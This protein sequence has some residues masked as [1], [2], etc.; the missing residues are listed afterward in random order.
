MKKFLTFFAVMFALLGSAI[1]AHAWKAQDIDDTTLVTSDN[2]T[3]KKAK[4]SQ[5]SPTIEI[6]TSSSASS[7]SQP[8]I[9][10]YHSNS[11]GYQYL[12]SNTGNAYELSIGK[13]QLKTNGWNAGGT[14]SDTGYKVKILN[15]KAS[16]TYA[17]T[18]S[19]ENENIYL[20]I[21][22]K[23][24][25][26]LAWT[27][28]PKNKINGGAFSFSTSNPSRSFT[29]STGVNDN[30]GDNDKPKFI[31][32]NSSNKYLI[33]SN[34]GHVKPGSKTLMKENSVDWWIVV[35][36]ATS[37]TN[38]PIT[39][40]YEGGS[41]Y[42]T[43]GATKPAAPTISVSNNM[44]T[45]TKTGNGTIYYTLDGSDPAESST[46]KVYTG[47]FKLTA[48]STNVNA[49]VKDGS[50]WSDMANK[51][52]VYGMPV[53]TITIS[54]SGL[55]TISIPES[56]KVSD[57]VI[58]Y[59]KGSVWNDAS[60]IVYPDK[61]VQLTESETGTYIAKY[62][63]AT[64]GNS[65]QSAA[66]TY[67]GVRTVKE[68]ILYTRKNIQ[69][70][71]GA[72]SGK[73]TA[74]SADGTWKLGTVSIPSDAKSNY[75][76]STMSVKVVY[77]D[78]T[79]T[80][81]STTASTEVN[82]IQSNG[83]KNTYARSTWPVDDKNN[84]GF[85]VE[86][87]AGKKVTVYAKF[88]GDAMQINA[89]IPYNALTIGSP[90]PQVT[91]WKVGVTTD[92]GQSW[93]S[94]TNFTKKSDS[95]KQYVYEFDADGNAYFMLK[96][97]GKMYQPANGS[98]T[99]A[100][101]ST[102]VFAEKSEAKQDYQC[103]LSGLTSGTRY[104]LTLTETEMG[105]RLS[106]TEAG[107]PKPVF[108]RASAESNVVTIAVPDG[109]TLHYTVN[110]TERTSTSNV[111]LTI[112]TEG[113]S[114]SAYFTKEDTEGQGDTV[115]QTFTYYNAPQRWASVEW[116]L[117][118]EGIMPKNSVK[119]FYLSRYQNDDRLSPEWEL[120]KN[121]NDYTLDYFMC[122][123]AA[124][125]RLRR[126]A[127]DINGN[128]SYRDFGLDAI[129][130]VQPAD[131]G[132]TASAVGTAD[133]PKQVSKSF[134]LY[135]GTYGNKSKGYA[136]D[137]GYTMVS[138]KVTDSTDGSNST[139]PDELT[140][141][142]SADFSKP[143]TANVAPIK[144]M[145]YIALTGSRLQIPAISGQN[146]KHAVDLPDGY[147][148]AFTNAWIQYD[149]D[150][151]MY[152]YGSGVTNNNLYSGGG[153]YYK[154]QD[155]TVMNSTILPPR[156]PIMF[157]LVG[158]DD[159]GNQTETMVTS[160][161]TILKYKGTQQRQFETP[162]KSK[163]TKKTNFA[164]Y[165]LN[166]MEMSGL[167][168]IYS[169][170]GGF[171]YG[172]VDNGL[173]LHHN[174]GVGHQ[175]SNE[176]YASSVIPSKVAMPLNGGGPIV[177]KDG[178]A[179]RDPGN[180][181]SEGYDNE[182]NYAG[183]Y[184]EFDKRTY[185]SELDFYYALEPDT[186]PVDNSNSLVVGGG[187]DTN[188]NSHHA[189]DASW[190]IN[191]TT[192]DGRNFSWFR[193]TY[194][195]FIGEIKLDKTGVDSGRVT[196]SINKNNE[197]ADDVIKHYTVTFYQVDPTKQPGADGYIISNTANKT[198]VG[199]DQ[200]PQ[201]PD[202]TKH[203]TEKT[204]DEQS[205]APG[206]YEAKLEYTSDAYIENP[207]TGD[208]EL[209]KDYVKTSYSTRILIVKMSAADITAKQRVTTA[210][211]G[212]KV[213]HPVIDVTP[214]ASGSIKAL[215]A[216]VDVATVYAEIEVE[217]I[218]T[219]AVT[220]ITD[221]N[222]NDL[223][224]YT[225]G[226]TGMTVDYDRAN[227]KATVHYPQGFFTSCTVMPDMRFAV[228]N[229]AIDKRTNF[230]MTISSSEGQGASSDTYAMVYMPAGQLYGKLKADKLEDGTVKFNALAVTNQDDLPAGEPADGYA[231][232]RYVDK[233]DNDNICYIGTMGGTEVKAEIKYVTLNE[234]G[235]H[236][237]EKTLFGDEK[238]DMRLNPDNQEA[239][240]T[241]KR[242]KIAGIPYQTE[243]VTDAS[244]ATTAVRKNQQATFSVQ[245]TYSIQGM[246]DFISR[247][248]D[249][250]LDYAAANLTAPRDGIK[251]I[252]SESDSKKLGEDGVATDVTTVSDYYIENHGGL[253][254]NIEDAHVA[255]Q[256][257]SIN[258]ELVGNKDFNLWTME[259]GAYF[260]D[261]ATYPDG[262]TDTNPFSPVNH[263]A[264]GQK[265][266]GGVTPNA[267]EDVH[268]LLRSP[269]SV[270][271]ESGF[272]NTSTV[273]NAWW[274][275]RAYTAPFFHTTDQ[276]K[277]GLIF[278]DNG[279]I[280]FGE[281][282]PETPKECQNFWAGVRPENESAYDAVW[283]NGY[284]E[285]TGSNAEA[286]ADDTSKPTTYVHDP[287]HSY[288][289]TWNHHTSVRSAYKQGEIPLNANDI[290]CLIGKGNG[291]LDGTFSEYYA[292]ATHL[293]NGAA[294]L[295]ED[296]KANLM[297]LHGYDQFI[298]ENA[299]SD[300]T[301]KSVTVAGK[302][303]NLYFDATKWWN[304]DNLWKTREDIAFDE[305][306]AGFGGK[307]P[308][309][310][311]FDN[312]NNHMIFKVNHVNHESWF[313]P[314][315]KYQIL[316]HDLRT[317][318]IW[319]AFK[320]DAGFKSA[321]NDEARDNYVMNRLRMNLSDYCPLEYTA[322][323][324][325]PFLTTEKVTA[326][327]YNNSAVNA[328]AAEADVPATEDFTRIAN[329][330]ST[331]TDGDV[332]NVVAPSRGRVPFYG[333]TRPED[334]VPTAIDNVSED[335]I[336][337]NGFS[338]VYNRAAGT[339]TVTALGERELKDAAVYDI[340]G[341]SMVLGAT[342]DRINDRTIVLD[343]RG[344]AQGAYIVSTNLG[345]AKFMK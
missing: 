118:D 22:E 69:D 9:T 40:S 94:W 223:P 266:P 117:A 90:A 267:P 246:E 325:Y 213:Y 37:S 230:S 295:S 56:E 303:R 36:N 220:R 233:N 50:D 196:W 49:K 193:F 214:D 275:Q 331:V 108:V 216:T 78:N 240:Y 337:G 280:E 128:I 307:S 46:A 67:S 184:F 314:G 265:G 209:H 72:N 251:D 109:C 287:R 212:V 231:R 153:S 163:K 162:D 202:D 304:L 10:I 170:Y 210:S 143:S 119:Y 328:L 30:N 58:K 297:V 129:S 134:T 112:P 5:S 222:G 342:A 71:N 321:A 248:K 121:G 215:D 81:Y 322:R 95:P 25:D 154:P 298:N 232:I 149:K 245:L 338:I 293:L 68:V 262:K 152:V 318:P 47:A 142:L 255:L 103:T 86:G 12:V 205:L 157:K 268:N 244:G 277:G 238:L 127:K 99:L 242:L 38:Y 151:Q 254:T 62:T 274:N 178:T 285:L 63:S 258:E 305:D 247:E 336:P 161:K 208:M 164:V 332:T 100:A 23:V 335:N 74:A 173:S 87:S 241:S 88:S 276:I 82:T 180:S 93:N 188:Y 3:Y 211:D 107:I 7:S 333:A 54:S 45:I 156:Y 308:A 126:V 48:S 136:W 340:S 316:Q 323:Y 146:I 139:G 114:L 145:P 221:M 115:S 79:E 102:Y 132:A 73:A 186:E 106:I 8:A 66:V 320:D 97:N 113:M 225:E 182:D 6:T 144:G 20:T 80:W 31:L 44:V 116:S 257:K 84:C 133:A 24:V 104:A 201:S 148:N 219:T 29:T 269:I 19:V 206:W 199:P 61:P 294:A 249:T 229:A 124:E 200:A 224:L 239:V 256:A 204:E 271:A 324:S 101:G 192:N 296:V 288:Y 263:L 181:T 135:G 131:I 281:K 339:V 203:V 34:E 65:A 16:T 43:L 217:G 228:R 83:W 110:G 168:K 270:N 41:V 243:T 125:F 197:T 60:A 179:K 299:G 4:F 198:I 138:V 278:H 165:A 64:Y 59:V 317:R 302:P 311:L 344:I 207:E 330:Y 292:N 194:S 218:S 177:N 253:F 309:E 98:L 290:L 105:L 53:P 252:R 306:I 70:G 26:P 235:T 291:Q 28:T 155:G 185:V 312:F 2:C 175:G 96:I 52:I 137:L 176:P 122:I 57:G 234:D 237:T 327:N 147:S 272:Q 191:N 282:G 123:P 21:A 286:A 319:S 341:S 226:A 18:L 283:G 150:A 167:F 42:M 140:M 273:N 160:N 187:N 85:F 166:D 172:S 190:G 227:R 159:D 329:M 89:V 130:K 261:A 1:P 51:T 260:P 111:T 289:D 27:F 13:N 11:D 33:P 141:T 284:I 91:G 259:H 326:E 250:T 301:D 183:R 310:Y 264:I 77:S 55:M 92:S 17:L 313:V 345:G 174:W 279:S 343:V 32:T 76:N 334:V 158:K 189:D 35:D 171:K 14:P 15:A 315:A 120:I 300:E 169:G 195:G 75:W 236:D 39:L